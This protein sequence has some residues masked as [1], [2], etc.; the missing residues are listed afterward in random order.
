FSDEAT[1]TAGISSKGVV[2]PGVGRTALADAGADT[3]FY[4]VDVA[5]TDYNWDGAELTVSAF[6][7][8]RIVSVD[9][10]LASGFGVGQDIT[11]GVE[12]IFNNAEGTFKLKEFTSGDQSGTFDLLFKPTDAAISARGNV[13]DTATFSFDVLVADSDGS[14]RM[15]TVTYEHQIEFTNGSDT[16]HGT[17]G[18]DGHSDS[19]NEDAVNG[20][21]GNDTIKGL[22][23]E[24]TLNGG[25]GDDHIRGGNHDDNI[26]GGAD[27]DNLGGGA[28][29]D[30]ING[31]AGND[32][33]F[34]S[35]GKDT[36]KGGADDDMLNGGAGNDILI[37]D[38]GTF[39]VAGTVP[40]HSEAIPD[41]GVAGNDTL[42]GGSGDDTLFG[43]GGN[44][45]LRGGEGKDY[46]DGGA[47][48][49]MIYASLGGDQLTGGAGDD[50]FVL[51]SG[52]GHTT[53]RDFGGTSGSDNDQLDVSALGYTSL[54]D[55]MAVSYEIENGF[56]IVID[57][58]TS[59]TVQSTSG[60]APTLAGL[61][62][63]DF[64]FA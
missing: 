21:G 10:K 60:T 16:Y 49:D 53:I 1:L 3:G 4:H 24:D 52:I 26:H 37:G 54:A 20:Q 58:D 29:D 7:I 33:V 50:T 14:T 30:T 17:D 45:E 34:G 22:N 32:T 59:V 44:D 12:K 8:A 42:R 47:G 23:G 18:A 35:V 2:S 25:A 36:L 41:S 39:D 43:G 46:L 6:A 13:G 55:I 11:D 51:K 19:T 31:E 62:S 57:D 56:V 63:A 40:T 64:D 61:S 9:G 38:D 28:G 48:N 27:D 15:V 5:A